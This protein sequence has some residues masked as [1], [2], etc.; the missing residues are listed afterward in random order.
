M[1]ATLWTTS[2]LDPLNGDQ[3]PKFDKSGYVATHTPQG[4]RLGSEVYDRFAT[5]N[6]LAHAV[7]RPQSPI[8]ETAL[9]WMSDGSAIVVSVAA[10]G[11]LGVDL[12]GWTIGQTQ[13]ALITLA[14]GASVT[15]GI[16]LV[17][18]NGWITGSPF[19]AECIRVA[20]KIYVNP[21]CAMQ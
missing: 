1:Y 2:G 7:S 19:I 14:A 6:D 21:V 20:D 16:V 9:K 12:S 13:T 15:N 3:L 10:S 11:T 17:G 8:T 4:A 18:Y 5:T